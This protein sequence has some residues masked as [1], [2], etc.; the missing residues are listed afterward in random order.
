M[1]ENDFATGGWPMAHPQTHM[2]LAYTEMV[3][4]LRGAFRAIPREIPALSD[5][6]VKL[7]VPLRF[8]DFQMRKQVSLLSSREQH[9]DGNGL[10]RSIFGVEPSHGDR[11]ILDE[12]ETGEER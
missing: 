7:A 11:S 6:E 10:H 2:D 3:L 5:E 12:D 4:F 1:V 9:A 8:R